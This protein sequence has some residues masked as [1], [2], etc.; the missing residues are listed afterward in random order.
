MDLYLQV[1]WQAA[2]AFCIGSTADAQ[3]LGVDK[4]TARDRQG[5]LIIPASTFKGRLRHECEKIARALGE[6]VCDSPHPD[7]MCPHY[8][9]LAGEFCLVCQ[10][11]GSPWRR[12]ALDFSDGRL[13]TPLPMQSGEPL[14][15]RRRFDAQVRPGVSISRARRAAFSE[16]LFF[17]ET[18][19]PNADFRFQVEISGQ[20]PDSDGPRLRALLL[21]GLRSLSLIGG[22]RSRGLGWGR[23]V[24][25][26][27][28]GEELPWDRLGEWLKEMD[29]AGTGG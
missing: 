20:L 18:S 1:E 9:P 15:Q 14:S 11:F 3:G 28:N 23:V 16:R 22:G 27:L 26:T 21:A 4:A 2:T 5:R 19:A 17:T 24:Q 10:L 25:W 8:G 12:S 6:T 7:R 13:T 29:H